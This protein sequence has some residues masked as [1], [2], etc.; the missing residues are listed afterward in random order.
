[1]PHARFPLSADGL[2]LPIVVGL[3]G[4]A[5]AAAVAAGQLPPTAVVNALI[6]TGSDATGIAPRIVRQLGLPLFLGTSTQSIAGSVSVN[7]YEVSLSIPHR[8][9][10]GSPLLVLLGLIGYA[11]AMPGE[12]WRGVTLDA[13]TLLAAS[14]AILCGYQAILF[15]IFTKTFAITEGLM[16]EDR[17]LARF[18]EVVNLERGLVIAGTAL[19]F[20]MGLLLAAVNQWRQAGFGPLDYAHTMRL[21]VPGVTLVA[22]AFQTI[23]SS[24]F[25]S[26][27]G[28]GR[29]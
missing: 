28:M 4:P 7:L 21:V 2:I 22:L 14:L 16:P 6:D 20:G 19:L 25:V 17:H 15:A 9:G 3:P 8:G 5:T 29:K 13:H 24:F 18:F 1:M 23:C 12:T 27:L 11:L 10:P 26:I